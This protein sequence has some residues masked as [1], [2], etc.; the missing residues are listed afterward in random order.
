MISDIFIER[1]RFALVISIVLMLAG[2]LAIKTL[3]ITQYPQVTPPEVSVRAR[4]PGANAED[5][6]NTV[7]IPLEE[8][9]NGVDDMLYMSS[10]CDDSGNYNLTVTFEIGTNLDLDMVK[11]QNRVQQAVPRLPSEVTKQGLAVYTR[12]SDM[13]GFLNMRSPDGSYSRLELSDYVYNH[14]KNP[15]ARVPGVG[16]VTV[17]GPKRSMRVWLDAERLA[18]MGMSAENVIAAIQAQNLQAALGAA[19]V[20]PNE[21]DVRQVLTIK[22]Q[23]RLNSPEEF[24]DIIVRT[25]AE[26]GLVRLHDVAEIELGESNYGFAGV[27]NSADSVAIALA[28][29]PGSNAIEAMDDI[30]RELAR[31]RE[32]MPEGMELIT[33]YD[34]TKFVRSSMKEISSTLAL[35]FILVVFV[36]YL[37]LQDW[38]A[39]LV[40]SITI[41]VSLLATFAVMKA[42]GYSLN[43]LTLFGLVLAIGSIVDDAIVVV[44]R[45]QYLMAEFDMERKAATRQT[46][47]EVTGAVIATTLVLLAIFIPVAFIPGITGKVYQQ[48][49]VT[50]SVS[51]CFSTLNALTLSPAICA[52]MLNAPKMHK[53]GPLGWFNG[54]LDRSR[55]GYASIA[56]FLARRIG[57]SALLLLATLLLTWS[58]FNRT[59]TSFLPE[60]DQGVVFADVRLPEGAIK[61]RTESV[62]HEISAIAQDVEGV[63]FVMAIT[64]FSMMGGRAENVGFVVMGLNHWDERKTPELHAAEIMKTLR[65]RSAGITDGQLN[66][67]MPP[68]IP[69]LGANSGLDIRLQALAESDPARLNETLNAFLA[70]INQVPGVQF[71]FSGFTAATPSIRMDVDRLKCEML[72]VPVATVFSTLQNYF[73]SFYVND[74][75]LDTQVN[76]VIIQ[77]DW[78]GRRTP[79][80]A[81]KLYVRSNRG[82][83]VPLGSLVTM[84]KQLGPRLLPRYNLFP[85][86]GISAQLV[87]G[88]SSGTV[89]ARVEEVARRTLPA[90]YAFE[91]SGLS[92]Q[93]SR[94]SGQ[95]IILMI[96][97]LIFG[98]LFLVAQYESWTIP[99]P[100]M[101]SIF[102]AMA[103][104]LIGINLVGMSLSIFAQL[105][106]VLLIALASKNAILIVEFSKVQRES[107]S[108]IVAAAA[109]GA[110][111]RFRAVLMTALTFVLGVL[112]MVY[113]TGA[114]AASRQAIGVATLSGMIAAAGFGILLV[115][116]LY[117]L[118]QTWRE[119]LGA[120][121]KRFMK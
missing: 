106:L 120:V 34:A 102:I 109:E 84:H 17:Y 73:G 68:S 89:M 60:E 21:G 65:E 64:G 4:Y 53:R 44:E 8:E 91:W 100:V 98:Y 1:P 37:F 39:T 77:S 6:A 75:N 61:S 25:E 107:G 81:L 88:A 116:G 78:S 110:S 11:V 26:G 111:Q 86:A 15:L 24:R 50:M 29:K 117:A 12:S 28:Q 18:A 101:F 74:V 56:V 45:V 23:G 49:A 99:M 57:L 41:P 9:I 10:E 16:D 32:R 112:P 95:T 33:A 52:T 3:P 59:P 80:D 58:W 69:G 36:C 48:F 104:A 55:R 114:G 105:G 118:F 13:L 43:T 71:A 113:A 42:V 31:L 67:F 96:A 82:A 35:T 51:I 27:F 72:D 14:I 121:R 22:T 108:S 7:A 79:E 92:F 20:S 2:A 97:A 46:M 93:E 85:S 76:Q 30:E 83:M 54:A 40:P 87:P 119:R 47:H 5:L 103:G 90:G 94:A 38:R 19:G 115:P 66:F 62:I 63:E 70:E